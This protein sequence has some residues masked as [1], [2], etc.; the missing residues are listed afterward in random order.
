MQNGFPRSLCSLAYIDY[1]DV[2][3]LSAVMLWGVY[4]AMS[5]ALVGKLHI[6]YTQHKKKVNTYSTLIIS[7]TNS[8]DGKCHIPYEREIPPL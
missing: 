2:G 7:Y 1:L 3:V 4:S 6:I 8:I 5:L